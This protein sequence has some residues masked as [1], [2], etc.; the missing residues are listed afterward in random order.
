MQKPTAR[1]VRSFSPLFGNRLE[2]APRLCPRIAAVASPEGE[3]SFQESPI[4][5]GARTGC[6]PP[7]LARNREIDCFSPS[8]SA[9]ASPLHRSILLLRA[10]GFEGFCCR[11]CSISQKRPG[12]TGAPLRHLLPAYLVLVLLASAL[13]P[14][15]AEIE[16]SITCS[17]G[18][19]PKH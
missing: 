4:L 13:K 7:A 9:G 15:G 14:C 12:R 11:R 5:P 6:L 2:P 10:P 17:T 1:R 19:C 3:Q 8:P 18:S 16:A